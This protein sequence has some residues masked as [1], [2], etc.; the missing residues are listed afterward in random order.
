MAKHVFNSFD[1]LQN[2]L[3]DFAYTIVSFRPRGFNMNIPA[4]EL[5]DLEKFDFGKYG[6]YEADITIVG[7]DSKKSSIRYNCFNEYNN[8]QIQKIAGVSQDLQN[9][10]SIEER[11]I[12]DELF[13]EIDIINEK[14]DQIL[15]L[16]KNSENSKIG[17]VVEP[18]NDIITTILNSQA[19][20]VVIEHLLKEKTNINGETAEVGNNHQ[21]V[22]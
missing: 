7:S 10:Q 22:Q 1:D 8:N 6:I 13:H 3:Y 19:V 20:G 12:E 15:L 17:S 2:F 14:I 4:K 21:N 16:L 11:E 5:D 9:E 18:K